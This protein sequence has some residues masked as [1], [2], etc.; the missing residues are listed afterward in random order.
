M[1]V[2]ICRHQF[3]PVSYHQQ[4]ATLID[5]RDLGQLDA[6]MQSR[7][8][9]RPGMKLSG[10]ENGA[11]MG[12]ATGW[13]Q[14]ELADDKCWAVA[15]ECRMKLLVRYQNRPAG[16]YHAVCTSFKHQGSGLHGLASGVRYAMVR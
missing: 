16:D 6:K 3:Q 5:I 8:T 2:A 10:K 4:V 12:L 1:S 11:I 7:V 9:A 14:V 13:G 15:M